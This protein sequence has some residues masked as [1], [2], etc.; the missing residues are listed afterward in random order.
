MLKKHA[1]W[2]LLS[3][4]QLF[5][6]PWNYTIH[7]I[8]QV[9]ILEWVAVR[10][11]KGSSQPMDRTQVFHIAGGFFTNWTTKKAQEYWHG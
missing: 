2:K 10:F 7:G 1:L 9:R 11:S 5:V 8:L 6:T 4:V 3:H